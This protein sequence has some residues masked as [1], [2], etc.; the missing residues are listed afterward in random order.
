M[1]I[2]QYQTSLQVRR[3][4]WHLPHILLYC[5][6]CHKR[7]HWTLT[8]IEFFLWK[9]LVFVPNCSVDQED[10]PL[11]LGRL[12]IDSVIV[13]V[14][15]HG[16]DPCNSVL[17]SFVGF[18]WTLPRH[19][20]EWEDIDF[21]ALKIDNCFITNQWQLSPWMF[22]PMNLVHIEDLFLFRSPIVQRCRTFASRWD[23]WNSWW[24]FEYPW[25]SFPWMSPH[26]SSQPWTFPK[27][28][29]A[30]L[31]NLQ[32]STFFS[33]G[34]AL[35]LLLCSQILLRHSAHDEIFGICLFVRVSTIRLPWFIMHHL[36]V[37]DAMRISVVKRFFTMRGK[38]LDIH[39]RSSPG[40]MKLKTTRPK[41]S[42][43]GEE[44]TSSLLCGLLI[45]HG[46][47]LPYHFF[48]MLNE[49]EDDTTE[50][51]LAVKFITGL[52]F[53]VTRS[54]PDP[55]WARFCHCS[56]A[57][58]RNEMAD[59][60]QADQMIPFITC[61]ISLGQCVCELVFGVDLF[62]LDFRT[63]SF[64]DHLD[65]CFIVLKHMQWSFL[66]R[67]LDIGRN[68]INVF[69]SHRS[70]F[71]TCDVCEHHYQVAPIDLKH[72]KYFQEQKQL[73]PMVPERANH[74]FSVQCPKRWF[75]ILLN[76]GKQQFVSCTSNWWEQRRCVM[77][78]VFNMYDECMK[79]LDSDVCH[80]PWS[81]L[82]LISLCTD[83]GIWSRPIRAK[84]KHFR[85]IWEH[86][87]DNSPTDFISSSVK[88]WSSMHGVD[89]L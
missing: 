14:A 70:S 58:C 11:E 68:R 86:I 9:F 76:C 7:C 30:L 74:L 38:D 32:R 44:P 34:F 64:N 78:L 75:Q 89:I 31:Q 63:P 21:C 55:C 72:E 12:S 1:T 61:E 48:P 82:W 87:C 47:W 83:H 54:S 23:P 5:L 50:G 71:E 79:S 67:G 69:P 36:S 10:V 73:D 77:F 13:S 59:V 18:W 40:L 33:V 8:W 29:I 62:D 27:L 52:D 49:V 56:G 81:I 22:F 19:N 57:S 43:L 16:F 42:S 20:T 28:Q 3:R 80:R 84:Y 53:A 4:L 41:A 51:I 35:G 17:P 2:V 37:P 24:N 65:H 26:S 15:S 39:T 60:K 85:T 45:F 25:N 46:S 88:W 6:F 66:T